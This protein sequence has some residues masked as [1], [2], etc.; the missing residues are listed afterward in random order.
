MKYYICGLSDVGNYRKNN[1]D[2]FLIDKKVYTNCLFETSVSSPLVTAVSDGVACEKFGELAS[3]VA[4]ETLSDVDYNSS[5]NINEELLYIHNKI[6]AYGEINP[7]QKNMQATLCCLAIDENDIPICINIGDSRMYRYCDGVLRQIS[8]DQS[9]VQYLYQSGKISE[10]EKQTHKDKNII[11][12]V[13]GSTSYRPKPQILPLSMRVSGNDIIFICSDGFSDFVTDEELEIGLSL[14]M[15]LK[16]RVV[17][18]AE[19]ALNR[20]STDNITIVALKS[21]YEPIE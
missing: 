11:F 1:E 10:S 12:P 13:L 9:L 8:T 17:T 21:I 14:N 2:C 19:L 7:L 20:G 18:L 5:T 16:E 3:K 15:P 6:L 4:L